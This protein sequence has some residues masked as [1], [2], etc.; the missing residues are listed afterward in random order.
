MEP[1]KCEASAA[2]AAG[3]ETPPQAHTIRDPIDPRQELVS[4]SS[5]NDSY[6]HSLRAEDQSR[7]VLS[8]LPSSANASASTYG[9]G[10]ADFGVSKG[11]TAAFQQPQGRAEHTVKGSF[12]H[13]NPK[14]PQQRMQGSTPLTPPPPTSTVKTVNCIYTP[15]HLDSQLLASPWP[16]YGWPAVHAPSPTRAGGASAAVPLASYWNANSSPMPYPSGSPT[17]YNSGCRIISPSIQSLRLVP[18]HQQHGNDGAS[19]AQLSFSN[20]GHDNSFLAASSSFASPSSLGV[21]HSTILDAPLQVSLMPPPYRG[22]RPLFSFGNSIM[23]SAPFTHTLPTS[24]SRGRSIYLDAMMELAHHKSEVDNPLAAVGSGASYGHDTNPLRG[25]GITSSFGDVAAAGGPSDAH[26]CSFAVSASSEDVSVSNTEILVGMGNV[27]WRRLERPSPG[28]SSLVDQVTARSG[29]Q[30]TGS[31]GSHAN[32]LD[33][34]SD[35]IDFG[36]EGEDG[37]EKARQSFNRTPEAL[38]STGRGTQAAVAVATAADLGQAASQTFGEASLPAPLEHTAHPDGAKGKEGGFSLPASALACSDG[39]GTMAAAASVTA[40]SRGRACEI[41]TPLVNLPLRPSIGPTSPASASAVATA[42]RAIYDLHLFTPSPVDQGVHV[43]GTMRDSA[44]R[45]SPSEQSTSTLSLIPAVGVWQA[46]PAIMS[47]WH[48]SNLTPTTA[49]STAHALRDLLEMLRLLQSDIENVGNQLSVYEQMV[50]RWIRNTLSMLLLL[51]TELAHSVALAVMEVPEGAADQAAAYT[52]L[53]VDIAAA[54]ASCNEP[55]H[56]TIDAVKREQANLEPVLLTTMLARGAIASL[57]QFLERP[58]V[59]ARAQ[60][61]A[62]TATTRMLN[63]MCAP[64]KQCGGRGPYGPAAPAVTPLT[65]ERIEELMDNKILQEELNINWPQFRSSYNRQVLRYLCLRVLYVALSRDDSSVGDVATE[66]QGCRT[67][68]D[69]DAPATASTA[70]ETVV[71]AWVEGQVLQWTAQQPAI[72]LQHRHAT[73]TDSKLDDADG[74]AVREGLCGELPSFERIAEVFSVF[75]ESEGWRWWYNLLGDAMSCNL[76][77]RDSRRIYDYVEKQLMD[78]PAAPAVAVRTALSLHE[79]KAKE[80]E[81]ELE[82]VE[83]RLSAMEES[84]KA[85]R[86]NILQ[87]ILRRIFVLSLVSS[88]QRTLGKDTPVSGAQL[89]TYVQ[90]QR[91]SLEDVEAQL[92]AHHTECTVHS[93]HIRTFVSLFPDTASAAQAPTQSRQWALSKSAAMSGMRTHTN[94]PQH[95]PFSRSS[96]DL[97]ADDTPLQWNCPTVASLAVLLARPR[98]DS[99]AMH[100]REGFPAATAADANTEGSE[101]DRTRAAAALARDV[102]TRLVATVQSLCALLQSDVDV[103]ESHQAYCA[104]PAKMSAPSTRALRRLQASLSEANHCIRVCI[105]SL[106]TVD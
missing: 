96:P 86:V 89:A 74:A 39:S 70:L 8:S 62:T 5:N 25:S 67:T 49:L 100:R 13:A 87:H 23:Q 71:S 10:Q 60:S 52:R 1:E 11:H 72:T 14:A 2:A 83:C 79:V 78:S 104:S 88:V 48:S 17:A 63:G 4:P 24:T 105:T 58:Y 77:V 92:S 69:A 19:P 38:A 81:V 45:N 47:A 6:Y 43:F 53:Q 44:T 32:T 21:V 15:L 106:H 40:L 65:P 91:K 22:D 73:P 95:G 84:G 64:S 66:Q 30:R 41:A 56:A 18:P 16:G 99:D 93:K 33:N 82:K 51:T 97:Q 26:L 76:H 27:D 36:D 29:I 90:L 35:G 57:L 3:S 98:P 85:Q 7:G 101:E 46:S 20:L 42:G 94:Q 54:A 61:G 80:V 34:E 28:N 102:A 31:L 68:T 103:T 37:T 9:P 59:T 50:R 12:N 75:G 55:L